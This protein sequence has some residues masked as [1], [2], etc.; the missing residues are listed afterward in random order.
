M[1]RPEEA[2]RL[3]DHAATLSVENVR[4]L[5][6]LAAACAATGDF[7]RAVTTAERAIAR[8]TSDGNTRDS[9]LI[10]AR[11]ELYRKRQPYRDPALIP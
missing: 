9:A 2:L 3:A 1:Q 8:A 7:A 11:L 4:V 10:R 6:T 5:D